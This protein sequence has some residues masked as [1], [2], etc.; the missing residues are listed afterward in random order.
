MAHSQA[1]QHKG[2]LSLT[3]EN[4]VQE[5][6][7]SNIE[8]WAFLCS[9]GRVVHF[10]LFSWRQHWLQIPEEWKC[11]ILLIQPS[12]FLGFNLRKWSWRWQKTYHQ[13]VHCSVYTNENL[14]IIEPFGNMR[15]VK[16][17]VTDITTNCREVFK[18]Y[19]SLSSIWDAVNGGSRHEVVGRKPRSISTES[20]NKPPFFC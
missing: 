10:N 4:N 7:S 11:C 13:D 1:L 2:L 9:S 19:R 15:F 3:L 5:L 12:D 8:K 14:K 16:R 17:V 20:W 6:M 18:R